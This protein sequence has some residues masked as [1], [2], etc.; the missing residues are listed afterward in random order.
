[1]PNLLTSQPNTRVL[2]R[3]RSVPHQTIPF[4]NLTATSKTFMLLPI[5]QTWT[6]SLQQS[7]FFVTVNIKAVDAHCAGPM[8]RFYI[9]LLTHSLPV[10]HQAQ[11]TLFHAEANVLGSART[12]QRCCIF[13]TKP[14][15]QRF[16]GFP[17]SINTE[18]LKTLHLEP[19]P[20]FPPQNFLWILYSRL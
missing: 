2:A 10:T 5:C 9:K 15:H 13:Q 11:S 7:S 17:K 14:S 18:T 6:P 19:L 3:I 16:R 1:L 4:T 12:L 20:S 8:T